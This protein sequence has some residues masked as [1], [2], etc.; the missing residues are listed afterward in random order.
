[1]GGDN[2]V[3]AL[4]PDY[5]VLDSYYVKE[6]YGQ[7]V[8]ASPQAHIREPIYFVV[9]EPLQPNEEIALEKVKDILTKELDFPKLGEEEE[10]RKAVIE[11]T[12]K[13]LRKIWGWSWAG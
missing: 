12:K 8:I 10:V 7:V 1:V 3:P 13:I 2:Q 9:E 11:T 6:K 4:K 5:M